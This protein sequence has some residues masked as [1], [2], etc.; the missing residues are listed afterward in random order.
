MQKLSIGFHPNIKRKNVKTSK[1][2][3]IMRVIVDGLKKEVRLPEVYDLSESDLLKWNWSSQRIDAKN[4]DINDY[5][6][7]IYSR[8]K[9][10]DLENLNNS[11][12][13]TPTE[14]IDKLLGRVELKKEVTIY[15]YS[16]RY[17]REEV[18]NSSKKIGTKKNYR[19]AINQFC[20]FLE[21]KNWTKLPIKE[22]KFE[23]ANL[24][25]KYLETPLEN[26]DI[27]GID[28]N[29]CIK[30]Y[31]QNE[32]RRSA[33]K[34]K[35]KI[36]NCS[37]ST[38]TKIKNIKPIFEKAVDEDLINKNPFLKI[39]LS[40]E[41][42]EEAPSL[43]ISMLKRI[44]ELKSLDSSLSY[45]KDIF[46]FMCFTG[47][48]YIDTMNFNR[49][50]FEVVDGEIHLIQKSRVKTGC[51]IRQILCNQAKQIAF[52][53]SNSGYSVNGCNVFP[54]ETSESI[55][56]KLKVIQSI[57]QIPFELSTK[58]GRITF[59][60][61]I[62]ESNI[63]NVFLTKKIMGWKSSKTIE[64]IYNRFTQND[65]LDA[66]ITFENYLDAYLLTNE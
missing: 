49:N 7:A 61:L 34:K 14:I 46:L 1:T 8:R 54:Y 25:K 41:G 47:F 23:N 42:T 56:R 51:P 60:N 62:R 64:D 48:A 29:E 37:V 19:N 5:L 55:N 26:L 2:Q 57:A 52:K 35:V 4:S 31:A 40:F 6:S 43:S 16:K 65:F 24:F 9:L 58:N 33:I 17:L 3:I 39:K 10:L 18:E 66:K 11:D 28:K 30:L 38:S 22:F 36:Q 44:Y 63:Q 45:T 59:K 21:L 27:L 12:V 32:S 20:I 15:D 50:E 53:Y 13:L